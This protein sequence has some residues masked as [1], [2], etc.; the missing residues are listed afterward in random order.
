MT[1]ETCP[2]C[3]VSFA[4]RLTGQRCPVCDAPAPGAP[5]TPTASRDRL[6]TIVLVA[7]S[8]NVV[9][10]LGIAVAVARAA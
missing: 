7:G 4:P 10:L 5:T 8:L 9:L 1:R 2:R 3:Q 6:L